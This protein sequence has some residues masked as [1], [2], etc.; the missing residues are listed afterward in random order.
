M[1][2]LDTL[3]EPGHL[4]RARPADP[5]RNPR[6][7]LTLPSPS[8]CR[9]TPSLLEIAMPANV[10]ARRSRPHGAPAYYLGRPASGWITATT[11]SHHRRAPSQAHGYTQ[12]SVT[13]EIR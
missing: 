1:T 7:E 6:H 10:Q 3:I 13:K 5:C 8:A 11:P 12:T 2:G 9:T 4:F